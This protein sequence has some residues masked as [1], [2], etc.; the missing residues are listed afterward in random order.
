VHP[1][2]P[3]KITHQATTERAGD[4]AGSSADSDSHEDEH[5]DDGG[6]IDDDGDA[7]DD[8][9]EYEVEPIRGSRIRGCK[10]V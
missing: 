2:Q 1:L 9:E 4:A 8:E 3:A 6:A 10:V 5:L 7:S